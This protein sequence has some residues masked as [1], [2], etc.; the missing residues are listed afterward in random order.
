VA[1]RPAR[2]R[3]FEMTLSD[4]RHRRAGPGLGLDDAETSFET[5]ILTGLYEWRVHATS[6][7]PS[8]A[9]RS[10]AA[11]TPTLCSALARRRPRVRPRMRPDKGSHGAFFPVG[12]NVHDEFP[13]NA[14]ADDV[15]CEPPSRGRCSKKL[16]RSIPV[17]LMGPARPGRS[18]AA[19]APR[20][21][22]AATQRSPGPHLR[23][24]PRPCR[25]PPKWASR[26]PNGFPPTP[27]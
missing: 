7:P 15:F 25:L 8:S 1:A 24:R 22:Q 21:A 5:A 13:F 19:G 12:P 4:P 23:R 11:N 10:I 14:R 17:P 27:R 18:Q 16:R 20:I 9:A 3:R 26:P 6:C 2:H